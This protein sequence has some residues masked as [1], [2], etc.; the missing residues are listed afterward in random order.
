MD[1]G[2]V[3]QRKGEALKRKYVVKRRLFVDEVGEGWGAGGMGV[4]LSASLYVGSKGAM[5]AKK[6]G[7]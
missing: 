2:E 4:T 3:Y 6:I 1:Y 7:Q 5:L